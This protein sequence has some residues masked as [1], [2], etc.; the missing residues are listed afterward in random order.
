MV[1]YVR[2]EVLCSVVALC[3]AAVSS[4]VTVGV[5]G[6]PEFEAGIG[7]ALA[8]FAL[9]CVL[10]SAF[11]LLT[12][13]RLKWVG[14]GREFETARPLE[15]PDAVLPAPGPELRGG[16]N[17]PLFV[18]LVVSALAG[19]LLWDRAFALYPLLFAPPWLTRAACAARWERRHGVLL[20]RGEV[21]DQP[22]GKGQYLYSSV[23]Q[24]TP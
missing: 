6:V 17:G 22:L 12:C 18:F 3:A 11:G 9:L 4:A 10:G 13:S 8:F 14:E 15:N 19:A 21:D 1:R 20:W 23:R 2:Y 5:R 24:P 7:K 16:V